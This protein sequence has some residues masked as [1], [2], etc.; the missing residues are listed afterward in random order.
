MRLAA[1][2]MSILFASARAFVTTA[3]R[4]AAATRMASGLTPHERF[5][6]DLNGYLVVRGALSSDEVA[7]L[8]GAI[9]AHAGDAVSR[10]GTALRNAKR[11]GAFGAKGARRDLGG[12]LSWEEDGFRKLLAHPK[13]APYVASLVGDGYRLDHQPMV[14][15]QDA[16][17]E[18]FSLHGGPMVTDERFNPELQYRCVAGRPWNSLVAMAAHLVDAPAGAG[19]FCVVRGSH[20]LNFALPPECAAGLDADFAREYVSQ[21]ETRAGDVVIFSEAT[22]HGALPWTMPYERRLALYRFSGPNYAYGRGYLNEWGGAALDKCT[23]AQR[24]VLL[25]PYA[26][27]LERPMVPRD[28]DA[29]EVTHYARAPE[30]KAHD[31]KVFGTDYF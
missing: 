23:P 13:L 11:A 7:A 10:D 9:D 20:K 17:S 2:C 15:L 29:G 25:P 14:L 19:G 22:I 16:G 31:V 1:L 4:R 5:L 12:M 24:A 8:N 26:P 18:G 30:K 28:G 3:T 21:V 6:F 27:R